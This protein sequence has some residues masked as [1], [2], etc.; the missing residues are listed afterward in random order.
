MKQVNLIIEELKPKFD[1][2]ALPFLL[3]LSAFLLL[4]CLLA[5]AYLAYKSH[6]L[7]KQNAENHKTITTLNQDI[8]KFKAIIAKKSRDPKLELQ[9]KRTRK[10]IEDR[11]KILALLGNSRYKKQLK[12]SD[13]MAGLARQSNE[14]VWLVHFVVE[15]DNIDLQGRLSDPFYLTKYI[16]LLNKDP[17]FVGLRFSSVNVVAQNPSV[18]EVDEDG[19][20]ITRNTSYYAGR[21]DI[22][23]ERARVQVDSR[24]GVNLPML[25]RTAAETPNFAYSEF[26]LHSEKNIAN[27]NMR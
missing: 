11:R 10:A 12:W 14:N 25:S 5:V 7:E 9:V 1:Y 18:T 21:Y 17:A 2:L 3:K 24:G 15:D 8:S 27:S 4:L 22:R 19:K 23:N 13:V 16:D 20:T 26:W 6:N